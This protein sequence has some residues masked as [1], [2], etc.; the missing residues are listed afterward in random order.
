MPVDSLDLLKLKD[1]NCP[2]DE[3]GHRHERRE[4]AVYAVRPKESTFGYERFRQ[5]RRAI[6]NEQGEITSPRPYLDHTSRRSPE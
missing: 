5:W 3:S 1:L 4:L 2:K 6:V